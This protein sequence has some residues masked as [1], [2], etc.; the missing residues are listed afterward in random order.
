MH[1]TVTMYPL[2]V[3]SADE[4]LE[5]VGIVIDAE[6]ASMD[7][8]CEV[9]VRFWNLL[10]DGSRCITCT[11]MKVRSSSIVSP[12]MTDLVRSG[13]SRRRNFAAE[14]TSWGVHAWLLRPP[15]QPGALDGTRRSR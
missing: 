10:H 2:S 8:V 7:V 4:Q 5:R 9:V 13:T 3:R 15:R 6:N 11:E 14:A 12:L 1:A